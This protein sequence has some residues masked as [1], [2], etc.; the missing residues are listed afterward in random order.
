MQNTS[1]ILSVPQA[2][3][4]FR[5]YQTHRKPDEWG[6]TAFGSLSGLGAE[7]VQGDSGKGIHFASALPK[8]PLGSFCVGE[9]DVPLGS[10]AQPGTSWTSVGVIGAALAILFY[11]SSR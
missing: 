10:V 3:G 1:T 8:V 9:G 7:V 4:R 2:N 5:Y 6:Q 11:L